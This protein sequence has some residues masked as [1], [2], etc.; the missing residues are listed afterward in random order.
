MQLIITL[1]SAIL[2]H[3]RLSQHP[4]PLQKTKHDKSSI[5]KSKINWGGGP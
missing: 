5:I 3:S 4:P 1:V 2:S